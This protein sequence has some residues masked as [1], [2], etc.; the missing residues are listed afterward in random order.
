M[1]SATVEATDVMALPFVD[2]DAWAD[3][4]DRPGIYFAIIDREHVVYVGITGVSLRKRWRH[5]NHRARLRTFGSVSVAYIPSDDD[6]WLYCAEIEAIKHLDP[7]MND[8]PGFCIVMEQSEAGKRFRRLT[9]DEG[10]RGRPRKQ[11]PA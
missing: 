6:A 2:M 9:W 4:P 7:V 1:V 5:H 11:P 3:L 8:T 10:I